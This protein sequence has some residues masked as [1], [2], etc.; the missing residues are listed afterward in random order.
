MPTLFLRARQWVWLLDYVNSSTGL[1]ADDG[2]EWRCLGAERHAQQVAEA[3]HDP[4]A[5]DTLSHNSIRTIY[6]DSSGRLWVGT[7]IGLDRLDPQTGHA[8]HYALSPDV[9]TG[10]SRVLDI[11]EDDAGWLWV[12]TEIAAGPAEILV[13]GTA[14]RL[15]KTGP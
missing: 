9:S 10:G 12:G 6:Q 11:L 3:Q 2:E 1:L 8:E 5:P 14:V 7:A 15:E 13:Y 4:D